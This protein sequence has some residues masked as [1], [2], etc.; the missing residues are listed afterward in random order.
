METRNIID[1]TVVPSSQINLAGVLHIPAIR[2]L[3]LLVGVAAAVA[4]GFYIVLWSQSPAYSPLYADLG[5]QEA[6]QVADALR[7]AEI[8]YKLNADGSIVGVSEDVNPATW[9]PHY[10]RITNETQVQVYQSIVGNSDNVRTHS[11]LD[12]SF[13]L[14]DN[15][16]TPSG[17][18]KQAVNADTTLPDSFGVFGVAVDD[19][20]FNDGSD[21]ISYEVTLAESGVYTVSASLR[22]QPFSY[23]HLTKLWLQGDRVDQVDK[24]RTIYESTLLRDEFIDTVTTTMQ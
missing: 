9:E 8:D 22:Y 14:K 6:A 1:S 12:G 17:F 18:D 2:Q 5:T 3:V 11:L 10:D 7:A 13:F 19:D 4:A 16:L 15:R 21:T 23:G 20:D 24:F